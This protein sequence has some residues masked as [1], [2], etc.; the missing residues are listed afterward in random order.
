MLPGLLFDPNVAFLL[1]VIGLLAVSWELHAPG[2]FI[3]GILGLCMLAVGALLLIT[4][5]ALLWVELKY[6]TH[7]VS[8]LIGT[9]LLAAGAVTLL[10]GPRSV[11]PVIAITISI[12]FGIITI[13]LGLLGM[14]ARKNKPITGVQTLI[15]EIGVAQTEI[16]PDGTI[17]VR[18]EY[19]RA[20]SGSS[21]AAGR[22]V[23]VRRVEDLKLY[24]EAV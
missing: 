21:I 19:W 24:V 1:V 9:I 6:Y 12:A 2:G 15:G 17:L 22:Q 20:H 8:G 16:D 4:A 5:I 13:F 18:G 11:N 23:C 7:M 10:P 3:A 14:R